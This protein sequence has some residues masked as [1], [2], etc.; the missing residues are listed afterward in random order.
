MGPESR[1]EPIEI[2]AR[3]VRLT[4]LYR[5]LPFQ[6][7]GTVTETIFGAR[8]DSPMAQHSR[9]CRFPRPRPCSLSPPHARGT[10]SP[11]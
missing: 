6:H 5:Y 7:A 9:C 8:N 11:A 10:G 2:L 4:G 1:L 3:P